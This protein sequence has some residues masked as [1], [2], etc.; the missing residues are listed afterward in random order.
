MYNIVFY[1][2]ER[3]DSPV[4][5]F[6]NG[7]QKKPKAKVDAWLQILKDQGPDLPRPFAD[8][9]RGKIRELR[10]LFASDHHRILY[11]FL[12]KDIV[13]LHAFLKKTQEIREQD[14][15]TAE[16]RMEDWIRRN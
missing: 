6:L 3:G 14:I 5:E 8:T 1:R 2:T 10:I 12:D 11:F 15:D 16:R 13:L 4:D 9:V 7:L